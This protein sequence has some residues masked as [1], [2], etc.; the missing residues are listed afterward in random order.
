MADQHPHQGRRQHFHRGRRGHDRRGGNERRPSP[1]PQS[2]GGQDSQPEQADVDQIIR[3]IKS[4][5]S[6][7]HG[8]DLSAQQIQE[9]AAR[10]LEAILDPRTVKPGLLDQLRK[11][12]GAPADVAPSEPPDA[13]TFEDHTIYDTHNGLLRFLRKLFNPLL[14][15]FFNPNPI[16][17][18]LNAQAKVNRD[19]ARR[20][21]ERERTQ[22][23]WNALHYTVLQ[24]LVTEVSR[25]SL[26][27]QSLALRVESLSTRADFTERR[28]RTM[29][30]MPAAPAA[31]SRSFDVPAPAAGGSAPRP[32]GD[33]G[34]VSSTSGGGGSSGG[35][36]A[37][38]EGSSEG[39]RRRR[40]RRRGR[41]GA[42]PGGEMAVPGAALAATQA[43][44]PEGEDDAFDEGP[45]GDAGDG[46]D[47]ADAATPL[48]T[49]A[50]V[51]EPA[52]ETFASAP[53]APE[54]VVHEPAPLAA[55]APPVL[56]EP[57]TAPAVTAPEPAA[58]PADP[59]AP[60]DAAPPVTDP[61]GT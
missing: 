56:D 1:Q 38:A 52:P 40:R 51:P 33:S 57:A 25:V 32:G 49:V 37:G 47:A 14:K 43:D 10:R 27:M 2:G 17:A 39:S 3:E 18:A 6:Q 46:F 36:N 4:R 53:A 48:E 20:E 28:I 9:L 29:E 55:A 19:A 35:G 5:I 45:E 54:P 61:S 30:A 23:E 58:H 8:I 13:F 16:A 15:L 24:R 12:A 50:S 59:P 60:P 31:P 22:A 41:R 26:E 21:S 42:G 7:R 44:A 11:A 34:N